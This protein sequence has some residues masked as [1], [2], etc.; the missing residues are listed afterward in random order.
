M[1]LRAGPVVVAVGVVVAGSLGVVSMSILSG[2]V[3]G[4]FTS[5]VVFTRL[6]SI[7][8]RRTNEK[9]GKHI[10]ITN[11]INTPQITYKA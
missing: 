6:V 8:S 1:S 4:L 9:H 3:L 11:K 2:V 10:Y 5:C 7:Q